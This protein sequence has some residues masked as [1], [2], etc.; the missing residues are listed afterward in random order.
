[1]NPTKRLSILVAGMVIA[2]LLAATWFVG[3][4]PRL[5]EVK[6]AD[7]ERELAETQNAMHEATLRG[8]MELAD[9]EDE[10][11][12][13]LEQLRASIPS[14]IELS[15]ILRR[16]DS[17]AEATGT[18]IKLLGLEG[19]TRYQPVEA[20]TTPEQ[21]TGPAADPEY[22]AALGSVT[23]ENFFTIALTFEI[24]GDHPQTLAAVELVQLSER[25]TLVS[26]VTYKAGEAT[27]VTGQMFVLL[28]AGTVIPA[29]GTTVPGAEGG[30]EG[31]GQAPE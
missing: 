28:D 27:V 14:D 24:I 26:D 1:M 31:E 20:D 8:L 3:I 17:V 6:A 13:D 18:T 11:S 10:L 25:F 29:A 19:P 7:D 12:S 16:L 22:S 15:Q 21:A 2:G 30:T 9:R 23:P 5:A 4:G